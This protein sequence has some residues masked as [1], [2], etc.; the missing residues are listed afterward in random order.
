KAWGVLLDVPE[1]VLVAPAEA[2]KN[3]LDADNAKGTLL[4]LG[5]GLL[6]AVVGLILVWLMARSVTRPTLGVA[7]ML[8][9]IASGEGDLTRRLAYAKQD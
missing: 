4:E 8:E 9:D 5:L 7:H 1:Q 2:L 6:A 3:Q